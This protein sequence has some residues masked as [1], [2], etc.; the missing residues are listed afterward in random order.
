MARRAI[1]LVLASALAVGCGGQEPTS[2][3]HQGR[4]GPARG[5]GRRRPRPARGDRRR[6]QPLPA[7]RRLRPPDRRPRGRLRRR[8]QQL[9]RRPAA[10][11]PHHADLRLRPR[12][13]RQQPSAARRP[14]RRR[15][16]PRPP[17]AADPRAPA[18]A[19]RRRRPLL[20]RAARA[21]VRRGASATVRGTVLVDSMGQDQDRRAIALWRAQPASVRGSGGPPILPPVESGVAVRATERLA[22]KVHTLGHAPLV[23]ITRGRRRTRCRRCPGACCAPTG[24]SG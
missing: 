1:S 17:A 9:E 16:A 18:A 24:G 23:V 3:T 4:E 21:H 2:R 20:R 10:P 7:L 8:Q 11:G 15:R 5:T 22:A 12:R 13:A 19:V 14:R 6:S